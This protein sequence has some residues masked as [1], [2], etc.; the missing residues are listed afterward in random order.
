MR[1]EDFYTLSVEEDYVEED[2]K[3]YRVIFR[4]EVKDLGLKTFAT[5]FSRD[6]YDWIMIVQERIFYKLGI[7]FFGRYYVRLV[8]PI[9]KSMRKIAAENGY[10]KSSLK[11][12][13]RTGEW[14]FNLDN[15]QL[16]Q[17]VKRDGIKEIKSIFNGFVNKAKHEKVISF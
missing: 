3:P 9:Y 16:V 1:K 14:V 11:D 7:D 4:L 17:E 13:I 15:E 6:E 8:R 2:I 10:T 12:L 5:D